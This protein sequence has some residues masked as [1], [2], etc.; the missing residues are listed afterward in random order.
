MPYRQ[1]GSLIIELVL[2]VFVISVGVLALLGV[3]QRW[4]QFSVVAFPSET[5]QRAAIERQR[6]QL[7]L[8]RYGQFT[9]Q[10]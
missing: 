8:V 3:S 2:G 7:Q 9:R 6:L 10:Q 5:E 4:M 1:R